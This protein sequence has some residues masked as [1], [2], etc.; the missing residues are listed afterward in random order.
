VV[1]VE[2][3]SGKPSPYQVYRG[4]DSKNRL[5]ANYFVEVST[6]FTDFDINITSLN[7]ST[8]YDAYIV[9]GSAHPGYPDLMSSDEIVYLTL[10]TLP[11][12]EIEV[13]NIVGA[14]ILANVLSFAAIVLLTAMFF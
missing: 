3:G 8:E 4:Y 5:V 10:T 1:C 7:P 14:P 6:A 2:A 12:P 11:V 13:L 9:G